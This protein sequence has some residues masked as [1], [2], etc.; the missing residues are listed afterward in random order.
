MTSV[1]RIVSGIGLMLVTSPAWGQTQMA[2]VRE[3]Y[4]SASYE[5]ALTV[6]ATVNGTDTAVAIEAEQYRA[7]CLLAIGRQVEARAAVRRIVERDPLYVPTEADVTPRIATLFVETRRGLLPAVARKEFAAAKASFERQEHQQAIDQLN[8]VVRM[9]SDP[10]ITDVDGVADLHL[11]ADGLLTL[12][13]AKAASA[14]AAARAALPPAP[15]PAPAPAPPLIVYG[16]EDRTVSVPV[17]VAQDLPPW[18]SPGNLRSG[19]ILSGLLRLIIDQTGKVENVT[20]LRAI[21][22]T[23]D[24]TLLKAARNWTFTP[25]LKDGQPVKYAKMIEVQLQEPE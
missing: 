14:A 5:D 11:V 6:L 12:A 8:R 24:G 7:L 17:A 1:R 22:P 9:T 15:P 20:L 21:H 10:V 23:Y 13:R 16:G 18:R 2:S 19:T 3:L 25:A 4:A